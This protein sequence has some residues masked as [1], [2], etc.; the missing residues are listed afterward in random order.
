MKNIARG[1]E[2]K[3]SKVPWFPPT[4]ALWQQ[5]VG[6]GDCVLAGCSFAAVTG[7]S[8]NSKARRCSLVSLARVVRLPRDHCRFVSPPGSAV[9]ISP[10][11]SG[12]RNKTYNLD[13]SFL[14][15]KQ[16]I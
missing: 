11:S 15:T 2:P 12:Y 5:R 14:T 3:T 10:H 9:A 7:A 8:Q 16:S 1:I 4:L 6:S 13:E